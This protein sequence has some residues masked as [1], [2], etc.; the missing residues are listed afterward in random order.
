[1]ANGEEF[2]ISIDNLNVEYEIL[3]QWYSDGNIALKSGIDSG[4]SDIDERLAEINEKVEEYNKDI[5]RLTNHADG[6]DYTIAVS[7]GI[8]CG[9]IDSFFVGEFS[10]SDAHN[11]GSEKIN[12]FVQSVAKKQSGKDKDLYGSVKYLEDNWKIPSDNLY[13][14]FGGARSHHLNDFAHHPTPVGLIF[15]ILTQFTGKAYGVDSFGVFKVVPVTSTELIGKD[16]PTKIS[17]GVITWFFHLVSDMAGSTTSIGN[18]YIWGRTGSAGTG[19]PGPLVSF[20]YEVSKLPFFNKGNQGNSD[21]TKWIAKLWNGTLFAQHDENGKIIKESVIKFDLRTEIGT[22]H[23][24]AKQ[25]FPVFVN[26]CVV[27]GFY[28]IRRLVTAIKEKPIHN[29]NDFIH[30]DWQS[31]L[32]FKN[33]TIVR[34]LTISTGTF[35]SVDLADAA[36]RGAVKSGGNGVVFLQQFI[37]RV[38]F[39]GIGRFAVAVGSDIK[40][41]IERN[42]LRDER[43]KTVNEELHLMN[44]RIFYKQADVWIELSNLNEMIDKCEEN[45]IKTFKIY[46]EVNDDINNDFQSIKGSIAKISDKNPDFINKMRSTLR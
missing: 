36:I 19:L 23:E 26:E 46:E 1:M 38:N 17:L 25:A 32:P 22:I 15:S 42:K 27:R 35:T 9:L 10:L 40:M 18:N 6:L 29:L 21:F 13:G 33:R 16:F 8:L 3:P 7:S 43:I 31:I 34:M 2:K 28:F 24:L 4:I 11:W 41:G 39:V 44:A 20:L 37:I 5:N 12:K 14:T 30:L 45:L